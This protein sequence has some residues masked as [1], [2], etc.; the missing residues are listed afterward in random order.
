M[1]RQTE[2]AILDTICKEIGVSSATLCCTRLTGFM[3]MIGEQYNRELFVVGR[4]VNGWTTHIN[5]KNLSIGENRTTIIKEI[6]NSV[7]NDAKYRP[8]MWVTGLWGS[9]TKYN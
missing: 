4:S 1:S 9:K 6:E 7:T 3:A 5:A 8:M 2:T